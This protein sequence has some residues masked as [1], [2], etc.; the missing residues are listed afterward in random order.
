[1]SVLVL[2]RSISG[3]LHR[4]HLAAFLYFRGEEVGNLSG[5]KI[6]E[7]GRT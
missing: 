4:G 2:Q 5:R 7:R 1:M 3:K 6:K